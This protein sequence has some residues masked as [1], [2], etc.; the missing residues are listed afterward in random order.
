MNMVD[1][2]PN[3]LIIILN[4]CALIALIK[5]RLSEWNKKQDSTICCL[6]NTLN[7]RHIIIKSKWM[8]KFVC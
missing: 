2:H 5:S 1:T 8:E 4:V 3:I 6:Q 7:M